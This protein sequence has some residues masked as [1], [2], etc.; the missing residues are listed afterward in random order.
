MDLLDGSL[1]ADLAAAGGLDEAMAGRFLSLGRYAA[2]A[3][4]VGG[5]AA[6]I[7]FTCSAF[8]PAIEAVKPELTIPV[9]R[10]N[11]AAFAEALDIGD[12]VALVVSFPPSLPML[13]VEL[14]EM[15]AARRRAVTIT[16]VFAEGALAALKAGDG[17]AHDAAVL[18]AC[19][20][21]SP[22]DAI[23]LGQFS[24]ARAAEPLRAQS[25]HPVITTPDSAVAAL[26]RL[27]LA[28][29]NG[30]RT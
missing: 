20:G 10:P 11:E 9:L 28:Q 16:P 14:N 6:A 1:S 7:L 24:L 22:Q 23:I 2:E 29:P 25:S 5:R 15:A 13:T 18:R 12:R 26:R 30:D 17:A 21:L 8:G 27:L 4:G 3:E 19:A